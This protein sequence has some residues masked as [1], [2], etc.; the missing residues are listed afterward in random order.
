MRTD[1]RCFRRSDPDYRTLAPLYERKRNVTIVHMINRR[2]AHASS[3]KD[4]EFSRATVRQLWEGG[5]EDV[6]RSCANPAW[7]HATESLDGVRVFDLAR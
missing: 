7:H 5:V 2:L 3:A 4:Y 1:R 6:R